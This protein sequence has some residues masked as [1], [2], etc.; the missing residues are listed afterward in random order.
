MMRRP[1]TT[2][3]VVAMCGLLVVAVVGA[4]GAV[5]VRRSDAGLAS[6]SGARASIVTLSAATDDL[7]LAQVGF[8]A[9]KGRRLSART[10]R[11]VALSPFGDDY[12]AGAVV[13]RATAGGTPRAL[14]LLVNRP[15]PLDDPVDVRL[16]VTFARSLGAPSVRELAD[17]FIRG[18]SASRPSL[19]DLHPAGRALEGS[20]LT[21][22]AT[23]GA[24][25]RGFSP[26]SA[27]AQAYDASCGLPYASAFEQAVEHPSSASAPEPASPTPEPAPPAPEPPA[28]P[29]GKL[30]GEGCKPT[31]GYACPG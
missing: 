10:L 22:L 3:T 28:P 1:F 17:P 5:L 2:V 20:Q 29:V 16:R 23:R 24:A 13:A 18:A 9:G 15:S 26:A 8:P 25:L 6:G 7:T 4:L 31:P 30:P 14:V 12:M 27:V 19:C 21:A 11:I